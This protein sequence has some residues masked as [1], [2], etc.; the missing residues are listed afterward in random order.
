MSFTWPQ[1]AAIKVIAQHFQKHCRSGLSNF[2]LTREIGFWT[3]LLDPAQLA[4]SRREWAGIPSGSNSFRNM[5]IWQRK[6]CKTPTTSCWT[7]GGK[8]KKVDRKS[9]V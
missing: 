4:Q 1:S 6:M 2:L 5:R 7:N 9:V 3:R 8:M